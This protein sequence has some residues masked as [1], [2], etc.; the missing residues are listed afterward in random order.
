ML[1]S[2]VLDLLSLIFGDML[3]RSYGYLYRMFLLW[4]E[5]VFEC[6]SF[7]FVDGNHTAVRVPFLYEVTRWL[8][9]FYRTALLVTG[10]DRHGPQNELHVHCSL[11]HEHALMFLLF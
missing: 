2:N 9:P 1:E 4:S 6:R 11:G 5:L 10:E 3:F 7:R 8:I